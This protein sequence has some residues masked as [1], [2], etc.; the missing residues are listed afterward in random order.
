M[1]NKF[2]LLFI[3][4]TVVFYACR[5]EFKN[6]SDS[7]I[8][9]DGAFSPTAARHYF[10]NVLRKQADPSA[11]ENNLVAVNGIT[12]A[13]SLY[14]RNNKI[15]PYWQFATTGSNAKYDYVELPYTSK[16]KISTIV[17]LNGT[18]STPSA[19][20]PVLAKSLN[21]LIIYKNKAGK[22]NQRLV[23][24]IPDKD[25][26][27]KHHDISHN[28]I[29]KLDEDFNGFLEYKNI[30]GKF[31]FALKIK[32]GKAIKKFKGMTGQYS[33]KS[34][35][36]IQSTKPVQTN[37]SPGMKTN[38]IMTYCETPYVEHWEMT[39][40]DPES[41]DTGS[42]NPDVDPNDP[43][44]SDD[45]ADC[46]TW[47]LVG[48]D[49]GP[50]VCTD[51]DDGQN[52]DPCLDPANMN[53]AECVG[54]PDPEEP[55]PGCQIETSIVDGKVAFS[56]GHCQRDIID[57]LQKYPC[58]DSV[59]N[60]IPS[61]QDTIA[62]IINK[63]FGNSCNVNIVFR[64]NGSVT[65]SVD[66]QVNQNLSQI[67]TSVNSHGQPVVSGN[68]VIDLNPTTLTS[69]TKEYMLATFYHEALHGAIAVLKV[70]LGPVAFAAKY[71]SITE[72]THTDANGVLATDA[73]LDAHSV[74]AGSFLSPLAS[75]IASMNPSFTPMYA[76]Q[77]AE[78]GIISDTST[79]A[80]NT[81]ERTGSADAKGTK[82]H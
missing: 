37:G 3:S 14:G 20:Q 73:V 55:D 79:I 12:A 69:S 71:P 40:C 6:E 63:L 46:G 60:S 51:Y 78:G 19:A 70:Q 75:A 21:R 45:N 30:H 27:A 32:N 18:E 65:G 1:K 77:L 54:D 41:T 64:A 15:Y 22:I 2:L 29:G 66:G 39:P 61:R 68:I 26:L 50:T 43:E 38:T 82:C 11:I 35:P 5:K 48:I 33:A 72:W 53:S 57:S 36:V 23:S 8:S 76:M 16:A 7:R 4:I 80:T 28:R 17:R 9:V 42:D 81:A 58:A 13:K 24:Y 56:V 52:D 10:Y 67:S 31:L 44:N 25:Y 47:Y 49:F 59:L 62:K 34:G 74:M